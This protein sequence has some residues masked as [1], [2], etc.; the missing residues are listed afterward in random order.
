MLADEV[1]AEPPAPAAPT[2]AGGGDVVAPV[3]GVVV[4]YTV[5]CTVDWMFERTDT[6]PSDNV[7]EATRLASD[8]GYGAMA[9]VEPSG[10]VVVYD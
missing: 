7:V 5:D 9:E 8:E 6:E 10:S 1:V 3:E 4:E 2:P